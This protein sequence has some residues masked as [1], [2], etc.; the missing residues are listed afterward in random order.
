[1]NRFMGTAMNNLTPTLAV[2]DWEPL[3][4]TNNSLFFHAAQPYLRNLNLKRNLL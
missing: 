2:E 4:T 1:M 3:L